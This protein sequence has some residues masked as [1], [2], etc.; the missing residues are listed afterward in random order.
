MPKKQR[1]DKTRASREGHEFHEAWTAR[2]ALQLFWPD[3][4][5]VGISVEGLSPGDQSGATQTTVE[6]ADI[7]L[8]FGDVPNFKLGARMTI[9]Q[10]K[11]S[12]A[13]KD[14]VFRASKAKGTIAKFAE[15]YR[16]YRTRYDAQSVSER[17]DFQIVTNQP[18]YR[19]LQEAI[20]AI[21]KGLPRTGE[22]EKQGDQFIQAA[23]LE[24]KPLA[25]FAAKVRIIG[26]SGS[27][28]ATKD[29]LV[30][31]LVDWSAATTDSFAH[32]R[33][34]RLRDLVRNKAGYAGTDQNLITRP[35]LLAAL[36]VSDAD[37]LLPCKPRLVDVG[38]VVER[39]QLSNALE[40]I[41]AARLPVLIHAAGGVGKTVFME[42][43]ERNLEKTNE[44][45]FFDCFGGGAY[46]SPDDARHLARHGLIHIANTLSFR[47]LCDPMLPDSPDQQML[48]RTFRRRLTQCAK[49]LSR[50]T[51]GRHLVLLIDAIDNAQIAACQRSE[52]A[53][54]VLLLESID[55]EP[56][57][58]VKVILSCR[59]HRMPVTNAK[60]EV[61]ELRPFNRSETQ[62]FLLA[63]DG[64][65]SETEVDVAHVRSGGNPRVLDYLLRSGRGLLDPSDID[66]PLE[67]TELIQ[68]QINEA[69]ATAV[70][71]GYE[72]DDINAFLAGLAVLPPPVP[73]DEYAGALGI[74]L[75]AVESFASDMFPLLER[76]CHGLTFRDEPTETLVREHYASSKEAL[77]QVAENLFA[78]QDQ[79][80]YAARALPGL[81]HELDHGERLFELAFDA[82]LP[83]S[84]TSTVG[85][86]NIRYAR[87]RAA[88]LHAALKT[89]HDKLVRLL[90]ALSAIAD[91]DQR[92]ASY[93]LDNPDLVVAARDDDALRRLFETRSG[94]PGARHARLAV[95][96]ILGGEHDEA[97]RHGIAA[98]EWIQHATSKSG[99]D[100]HE[101]GPGHRDIA[102]IP[103][104]LITNGRGND[105]A[106]YLSGWFDWYAFEVCEHVFGYSLFAQ[107]IRVQ[108]KLRFDNYINN[109]T[110][111][112]HI[113]AALS[114]CH[115][116]KAKTRDLLQKLSRRCRVETNLQLSGAFTR[117]RTY[118]L[119]DGLR[120]SSALALSLGMTDEART[121]SLRARHGRPG[122]WALQNSFHSKEVF[123]F[124]YRTAL[125]AA[126]EKKV[127]H[128]K[129]LLPAELVRV[130]ARIPKHLAGKTF[131][132]VAKVKLSKIPRKP[133]DTQDGDEASIDPR[134]MS[135][136]ERQSADRFLGQ[137][138]KPLYELTQA[139]SDALGAS[140]QNIDERFV[141][142]VE[143]WKNTRR[144]CDSYRIGEIDPL[145]D[146]LGFE[147]ARFVLWTRT[148][149]NEESVQR[150]LSAVHT[151]G[152]DPATVIQIITILAR[153]QPLQAQA[154]A[155][156]VKART[157]I[158]GEDDVNYRATLFSDLARAM[159]PASTHEAAYFF[160]EGLE[161]MDAIGSGD[162]EFTNMLLLFASTIKGD[163]LD[164]RDFHTL[165]N[166]AELN[167]GEEPE[168][169]YWGAY[170]R[171]LAM[172]AGL[173]G[174][175]KLSRWD[176]R[177]RIS[178]ANTLLPYLIGLLERGKISPRD[179]LALNRLA[180]PVEYYY[181]ST[182]EFADAIREQAGASPEVITALI[183]QY[184]DDN[185]GTWSESTTARLSALASEALGPSSK[186]ARF[187]IA[188][189]PHHALVIDTS[190]EQR[191]YSDHRDA[192]YH[193]KRRENDRFTRAAL[194]GI[195]KRTDPDDKVSLV[196]AISEFNELGNLYDV[197]DGF[198]AA[199]REK[200][201]YA[202]RADYVKHVSALEHLIYYR[203]LAELKQAK[204][205]WAG[206]SASLDP[207]FRSLAPPLIREYADDLISDGRFSASSISE[208]SELTGVPMATIVLELIKIFA[209]PGRAISGPAWLA[210]ASF[211]SPH[212]VEGQGQSALSQLLG[213]D[214]A[215]LANKVPDGAWTAGLYPDPGISEVAAGLV[216]R[217]LGSPEA[218][219]RWRAT[220]SMRDF[221]AFGN[222]QVI[223]SVVAKIRSKTAGP[224]QAPELKFYYMH[225]RLWLLI[226]LS[227]LA[228]DH[229]GKVGK[230]K[231]ELFAIAS[232]SKQPHVLMRH[233]AA[234]ALLTCVDR[235]DL[236]LPARE[237]ELVSNADASSQQR[238][239]EKVNQG[240]FLY[241][242]RPRGVPEPPFIFHLDYGFY[243]S[244]V[245]SLSHVFGKGSW[246]VA[247][248][249]SALVHEIDPEATSMYESGGREHRHGRMRHGITSM[250]HDYGQQLGWHALFL[251][252][253]QLLASFP[254]TED[255]WYDDPWSEWLGRSLLS[256]GDGLWLSDGTDRT[257]IDTHEILLERE[258]KGL[259]V[260]GDQTKLLSLVGIVGPK[261][262][263]EL[264]VEGR[265]FSADHLRI[266]ISSALVAP[267][268]ATKLARRVLKEKPIL[269]WLPVIHETEDDDAIIRGGKKEYT[270]WVVCPSVESRIDADDPYGVSV[271]NNRPRL[272][273]E[274]ATLCKLRCDDPFHRLWRN[275]HGT[276][277]LHAEAWGRDE[278]EREEGSKPGLR[279]RC[280]SS[281]LRRILTT[282]NVDLLL[283]I[284]LQRYEK[285][286]QRDSRFTHSV[287]AVRI[288]K[289]LN[290]E[291]IR[292]K[293]N[294]LQKLR[295]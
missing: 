25:E 238:L 36:K 38:L 199:L 94:W 34:G 246:E 63:R 122:V 19:P 207:V 43:L 277:C 240:S 255:S 186:L 262:G 205:A 136:E 226:A 90:V 95:A 117:D 24:G 213:S 6:I 223:D 167:L 194:E 44:V 211:I 174:L 237:M 236:K 68:Q 276:L 272:A 76:T 168:K 96:N 225:A 173:R 116:S 228:R 48:L 78:R 230:Y 220:H 234:Q 71:R 281:V 130:C 102:A 123:W 11:Y 105:A 112:G 270:P 175:A 216:W 222:W 264:V 261:L 55:H 184:Q 51:P 233:F 181:S 267:D 202:D 77:A 72:Q 128:E 74:E 242:G 84:V 288:N 185:P 133:R 104:L 42:S 232:E 157:L 60:Y 82:R 17:L 58:G 285:Q 164:E 26:P 5:L 176:D 16:D 192:Q 209:R 31:L 280:R 70:R 282:Y 79:S 275:S 244:D 203:K 257:P 231:D 131:L 292:G 67:L 183:E 140:S 162:D 1:I 269:A 53:F 258:E 89:D 18:V 158:Q 172:V 248:M 46:R 249:I 291:Y 66:K 49:T 88:T 253:G 289:S 52:E 12:I 245:D 161:Q 45:V 145:F 182:K 190:N 241:Q 177:S 33:L 15:S 214:A 154:G 137:R 100:P 201:N 178:L 141:Q 218:V 259:T 188:A 146:S 239:K 229:P 293:T 196:Q 294:H 107:A 81:L 208:I 243:K 179:A 189:V 80:V 132:D 251:T 87:L 39:E 64:G 86:R 284:N 14:S 163:E 113:A 111:L 290:V 295:D 212:A 204:E 260:T 266:Q 271:A 20:D 121:I 142:L 29:E 73:L 85:Q 108:S 32:E 110:A 23:G 57:E 118:D 198:F 3:I 115:F 279:L 126:T 165:S 13:D 263:K 21:A 278:R 187:L 180:S 139:L 98:Y 250:F 224:F 283:L 119:E 10:F 129:D 59:S 93:I 160:R 254:I 193:R 69:L 22:I 28:R 147:A 7:A 54:P 200:L 97:H 247:D 206:S 138:L 166:I 65:A 4:G 50:V 159:L 287:A 191:N 265:W 217:A 103:F 9:A 210:F 40:L 27:L 47:G 61:Y 219:T 169:F 124:I 256:R 134:A 273:R 286:F 56:I 143:A 41:D 75:S 227:R 195:V 148:N 114:F 83:P 156:A 235:G 92:G 155:E 171:G 215:K 2:K 170:G 125:I 151:H 144:S 109:L 91:V 62:A 149:I 8:Y 120:R 152:A 127:I 197:K 150:F 221:A 153:R 30:Y 101:A 274:Y 252:A 37:D 35:D 106:D 135:D 268:K 99:E